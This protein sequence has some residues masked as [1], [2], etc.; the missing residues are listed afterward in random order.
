MSQYSQEKYWSEEAQ[1]AVKREIA[2]LFNNKD[3]LLITGAGFS[4]NFGYPLWKEFLDRVNREFEPYID[5]NDYSKEETL[6]YLRF[7]QAIHDKAG[8]SDFNY[9]ITECFDP[10]KC[11]KPIDDFYKTLIELGFRGFATLN[12]DLTL[13][14][15]INQ[16]KKPDSP[17]VIS[18]DFCSTDRESK[19]KKFLDYVS[20]KKNEYCYILHLHG[21]HDTPSNIILTQNSYEKWYENGPITELFELVKILRDDLYNKQIY[22]SYGKISE[23]EMRIVSLFNSNVLQTLHKKIIWSLFARY[24]ILFIGFSTDDPFFMNLLKVVIDDFTLPSKPEHYILTNY[25]PTGDDDE[26]KGKDEIC[27]KMINRGVF[28]IFYPVVDMDYEKGLRDFIY[29][30]DDLKTRVRDEVKDSHSGI[31]KKKPNS[32]LG[33]SLA[34]ITDYTL[35]LK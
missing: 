35:G 12:Y 33:K 29:E 11:K 9:N 24:K 26:N 31:D 8:E 3:L 2:T 6:D 7:A 10:K 5:E 21:V 19:V 17:S 25:S 14:T 30:I 4:K 1:L 18:I 15:I 32:R 13:E 16:F 23:L 34:E 28:P 27:K 22:D 20:E